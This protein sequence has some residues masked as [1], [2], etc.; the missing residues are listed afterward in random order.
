MKSGFQ[1]GVVVVG[2]AFALVAGLAQAQAINIPIRP[3]YSYPASAAPASGPASVRLAE[4]PVFMTPYVGLGAG[5]DDN[6][7]LSSTNEK[8]S[9]YYVF[10]PGVRLDARDANKVF[11]VSYQ[12]TIGRYAQSEPDNYV[13]HA[14]R[15]S[16]DWALSPRAF[17]RLQYDY[18]RGHDPRGSTDRPI[19]TRADKYRLST[20]GV[21]FAY[22]A[23]GADGRVEVYYSDAT[24]RYTNN[25]STTAGSDR[26]TQEYGAAFYWRVMPR[27]YF[28]VEAR[29]TDLSYKLPTSPFSGEEQRFYG[30]LMWEATA[31]TTGTLKVGQLRKSFDSG[32]PSYEGTG[33]EGVITWSPRT[34]SKFDF[35][36][37][38]YP[39]ESTGQG[40]FILTDAV[41]VVWSH[42]WSSYLSTEA[43]VRFQ[44]DE[45]Q[46]FSRNDDVTVFGMKAG[47]R[48]R[49][50][51]TLGAEY[52]FTK[53][54][55]NIQVNDYDKNLFLLTAT[56]SM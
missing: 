29:Q 30:G 21:T 19:T 46:G 36:G 31:A 14:L 15:T 54:D 51:L 7:F 26:D 18:L 1:C 9:T 11:M 24:K 42:A 17:M 25:P 43:N 52:T 56:I 50:W 44:S 16:F 3:T 28:V 47:Y 39:T 4:S 22:G 23:P 33:W 41:G 55:S 8:S 32:L 20:P 13:D 34:Y 38:R 27:T 2:S 53:R 6:L 35:Y 40:R 48:L 37:G 5:Y 12:G 45:Y 49:R 10:S